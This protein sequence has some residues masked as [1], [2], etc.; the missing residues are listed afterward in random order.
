MAK[1]SSG[2][3]VESGDPV[4]KR[5]KKIVKKVAKKKPKLSEKRRILR[6]LF[7]DVKRLLDDYLSPLVVVDQ[8]GFVLYANSA[9]LGGAKRKEVVGYP[10][11]ARDDL[12]LHSESI[13]WR[14]QQVQLWVGSGVEAPREA[15]SPTPAGEL[16]NSE[17][18]PYFEHAKTRDPDLQARVVSLEQSEEEAR[19]RAAELARRIEESRAELEK[20]I[21]KTQVSDRLL[22]RMETAVE[23]ANQKC[24]EANAKRVE[25]ET[26]L[27]TA[28]QLLETLKRERDESQRKFEALNRRTQAEGGETRSEIQRLKLEIVELRRRGGQGGA[29]GE[30]LKSLESKLTFAQTQAK[31]ADSKLFDTNRELERVQAKLRATEAQLRGATQ[32]VSE[33]EAQNAGGKDNGRSSN[34]SDLESYLGMKKRRY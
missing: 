27:R 30:Q 29:S 22:D 24:Q 14:E 8:E 10:F 26:N 1:S 15:N 16:S 12:T 33:L 2:K 21:T 4:S 13:E 31:E 25:A 7:V 28:T 20:A 5:L 6:P 3:G 17:M 19:S 11:V 23:K 34:P 18:A 9:A 32:R